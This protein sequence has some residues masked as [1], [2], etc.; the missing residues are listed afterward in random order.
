MLYLPMPGS[1]K[2]WMGGAV[3]AGFIQGQTFQL[4]SWVLASVLELPDLE[5]GVVLA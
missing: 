1:S 3:E 4:L 5:A 2:Y